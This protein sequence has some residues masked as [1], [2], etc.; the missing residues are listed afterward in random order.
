MMSKYERQLGDCS[1]Y[2]FAIEL[3]IYIYPSSPFISLSSKIS[4]TLIFAT[5]VTGQG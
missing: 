1:Y 2:Q 5:G 4:H 3:H